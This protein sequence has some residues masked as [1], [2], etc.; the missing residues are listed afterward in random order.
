MTVIY[1]ENVF[2]LNWI[3]DY[4]LLMATARLAGAPLHRL[5]L[6]LCAAIGGIYA[7]AV[8]LPKFTFLGNPICKL[9]AGGF[10]ALLAY[11]PISHA[12]RLTALFFLLSGALAGIVLGIALAFGSAETVIGRIYY[13]QIN[14]AVLLITA[15]IMYLLLHLVFRQGARHGGGELMTVTV[16]INQQHRQLLT[17]YDSGNTLRD[18]VNGQA[19]LVLEQNALRGI[20]NNQVEAILQSSIPPE[21]KMAQLYQ[22]GV[23]TAF[24][25][26]PFRSVGVTSGLLLAVRSDY[27]KVGKATYPRTLIALSEGP[28]SDGGTYQALWGGMERRKATDEACADHPNLDSQTQQAG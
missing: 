8:F 13:E 20:W 26:L 14:W 5:R 6:A 4:L 24:T 22:E 3:I 27:I 25:L 2:I 17:L 7:V 15:A 10:M 19:V 18:P 23:G 16:S 9:L 28:V 21:E 11:W 1:I 12:W